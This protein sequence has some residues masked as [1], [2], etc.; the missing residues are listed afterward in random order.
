MNEKYLY[1]LRTLVSIFIRDKDY[2]RER[3]EQFRLEFSRLL[4]AAETGFYSV[5]QGGKGY[6]DQ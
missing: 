2:S 6:G 1:E 5:P 3:T 4:K